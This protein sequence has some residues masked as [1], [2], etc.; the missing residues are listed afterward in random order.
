MTKRISFGILLL[1]CI[2]L[3]ACGSKPSP[4]A[5]PTPEPMGVAVFQMEEPSALG[6]AIASACQP[7]ESL[8]TRIAAVHPGNINYS[9]AGDTLAR[10][11]ALQA[12]QNAQEANGQYSFSSHSG[13]N[14]SYTITGLDVNKQMLADDEQAPA[15]TDA[16]ELTGMGDATVF[17]DELYDTNS[18]YVTVRGTMPPQAEE[19]VEPEDDMPMALASLGEYEVTGGGQ[20]S[21]D[22]QC[23]IAKDGKSGSLQDVS[24]LE[25]VVTG[26]ERFDYQF[27]G[28]TLYFTD[29]VYDSYDDTRPNQHKYIILAGKLTKDSLDVIEYVVWTNF[30]ELPSDYPQLAGLDLNALSQ[31]Y[32]LESRITVSGN[33]LT[34]TDNTGKATPQT[35]PK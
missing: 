24:T 25:G 21:H 14:Y 15:A 7:F 6:K 2:L 10:I 3:T 20:F 28:Q 12:L 1:C 11:S 16:P 18:A 32:S 13:G 35:L 19:T 30:V 22:T 31:R 29:A 8:L 17:G 9:I 34:L 23:V 5:T 27:D 26:F 33:T 4:E